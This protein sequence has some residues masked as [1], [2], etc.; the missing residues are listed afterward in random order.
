MGDFNYKNINWDEEVLCGVGQDSNEGKFL[1]TINDTFMVQLVDE[2]T[3][4]RGTNE[5]KDIITVPHKRLMQKVKKFKLGK[6]I[7]DWI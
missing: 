6:K 7:N 1:N 5:A 3:R 2:P 4:C